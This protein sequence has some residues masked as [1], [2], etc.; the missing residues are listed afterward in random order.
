MTHRV[1][2]QTLLT[3]VQRCVQIPVDRMSTYWTMVSTISQGQV[4]V[5]V[6]T[7]RTSFTGR[8]EPV[9]LNK[10]VA[11]ILELSQDLRHAGSLYSFADV[12]IL[13]FLH[14]LY[15]QLFNADSAVVLSNVCSELVNCVLFDIVDSLPGT[16][17]LQSRFRSI[18]GALGLAGQQ[19]LSTLQLSFQVFEL[20]RGIAYCAVARCCELSTSDIDSNKSVGVRSAFLFKFDLDYDI[21]AVCLVLAWCLTAAETTF[22]SA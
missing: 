14:A 2:P 20:G 22:T 11:L 3:E 13:A 5:E 7:I 10:V 15:V 18:V 16:G 1:N 4:S 6:S 19:P 9:N 8:I 12:L 21:P 17:Y